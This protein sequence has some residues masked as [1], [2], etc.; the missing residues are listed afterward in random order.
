MF[1]DDID[2]A[3]RRASDKLR[4]EQNA[5][6]SWTGEVELNPGPSAQVVMLHAALERTLPPHYGAGIQHYILRTQNSDGGWSSHWGALSDVSLSIECYV[7]LRLLGLPPDH[8]ALA[9]AR[10]CIRR[11]G[12]AAKA[13]AWT[14]LY[15]AFLGIRDWDRVARIPLSIVR[16][17]AWLPVRLVHLSYWVNVITVPMALLGAVGPG[18]PIALA[19]QL[20]DELQAN[21]RGQA[22]STFF[23]RVMGHLHA[24]GRKARRRSAQ[25]DAAIDTAVTMIEHLTEAHGD[26]GGNT[27]TAMNVLMAY[28]MLAHEGPKR[29]F[30]TA[31]LERGLEA[32]MGYGYHVAASAQS[33][34]EWH[35]QTCQS[36]VWDTGFALLALP[37]HDLA[38]QRAGMWLRERQ[39]LN[40][41][42]SWQHNVDAMPG[43]WCFGNWHNHY[44]VTDC[45]ALA[46]MGLAHLAADRVRLGSADDVHIQRGIDWLLAMQHSSGGWSAYQKYE[47]GAWLNRLLKFKDIPDALVDAPKADVS[48]KVVEA[49]ARW[50]RHDGRV[51]RA[52]LQARSFLLA[53][54]QADGVVKGLWRGNYGIN[55]IY[56]T[57]FAAKALRALDECAADDWAPPVRRFFISRQQI[58]GSWGEC[59]KSYDD[60]ILAGRGP[61]SVVQT[62]WALSG[63]IAAAAPDDAAA[64]A[65]IS[66]G[67]DY[68]LRAQRDDGGWDE[69][70]FLGT[71]FPKVVYFRY[72][73]YPLYFPMIAL[74]HAR[75]Y[76]AQRQSPAVAL[77]KELP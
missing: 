30:Y 68:L 9:L 54:R 52:L 47:R 62:S 75:A 65:A 39:I 14:Q 72:Q 63:L 67:C 69:P 33:P 71:V 77:L 5:D 23:E 12:G 76:L 66:K 38:T 74:Q 34:E 4:R 24:R 20:R 46:L 3:V 37:A 43:G 59:E 6:G 61:S 21:D 29:A 22:G 10:T 15:L 19:P 32:L 64:H 31:R 57:A 45:T 16:M 60:P 17:P 51:E 73:L 50:R 2:V 53:Q 25:R 48:A 18:N 56:G 40:T 26:F 55:Y 7:A 41:F 11:L 36:H 44:P 58:D 27:C 49:L 42:G 13:N 35:F 28:H 70:Y 8:A 1:T